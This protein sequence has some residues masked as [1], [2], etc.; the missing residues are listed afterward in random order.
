MSIRKMLVP[1]P[2]IVQ[3]R[4]AKNYRESRM[5]APLLRLSV[6]ATREQP[7]QRPQQPRQTVDGQDG[8]R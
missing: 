7:Q 8:G 3:E 1:H 5:R 4:L 6:R 2:R